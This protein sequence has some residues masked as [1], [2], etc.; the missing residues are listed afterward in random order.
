MFL[1][2][3]KFAQ[4]KKFML[5]NSGMHPYTDPEIKWLEPGTPYKKSNT[6]RHRKVP[7]VPTANGTIEHTIE[8]DGQERVVPMQI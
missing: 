6:N 2:S 8:V 3:K 5:I 7:A 4:Q 1:R